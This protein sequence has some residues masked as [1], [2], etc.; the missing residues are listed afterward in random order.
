MK[1]IALFVLLVVIAT[2]G[3]RPLLANDGCEDPYEPFVENFP[4]PV[5]IDVPT[6]IN[7][8]LCGFYDRDYMAFHSDGNTTYTATID[9]T[10]DPA[11]YGLYLY[12][13]YESTVLEY[14]SGTTVVFSAE[15]AGQYMVVVSST[16]SD[17][18]YYG[19]GNYQ[20]TLAE[21]TVP[22]AI[23]LEASDA[24]T[25]STILILGMAL[26]LAVVHLRIWKQKIG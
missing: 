12:A 22:T 8:S 14:V 18:G 13:Y 3:V 26:L 9:P 2:V 11:A 17:L 4:N 20:F 1:R 7:R 24:S 6:Q 16:R 23:T 21:D 10:F 19:G 25:Q 5:F 15:N